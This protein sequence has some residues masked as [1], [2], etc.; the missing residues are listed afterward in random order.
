LKKKQLSA[1]EALQHPGSGTVKQ[2]VCIFHNNF[3]PLLVFSCTCS[4]Y[5]HI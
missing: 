2:L 5:S 1:A 4:K 3:S